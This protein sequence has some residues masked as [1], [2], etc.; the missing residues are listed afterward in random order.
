MSPEL[1]RTIGRYEILKELGRGTMGIVYQARDPQIGR[2]VVVK[3]VQPSGATPREEA[4]ISERFRR[5]AV[6]AGRL[7]HPG[8]VMVHDVGVDAPSGAEY[9]AMEMVAGATLQELAVS[10]APLHVT[11][12]IDDMK[13][14]A[15][16]LD[17]AH[18]Q[19]IVHRDI[20]PSNI[21]VRDDGRLKVADFGVARLA[22]SSLTQAGQVLGSPAY[23]SPEQIAGRRIDGRSDQFS[24]A[25]VV[26]QLLTGRRPFDGDNVSTI[27]HKV[28]SVDP[29]PLHELNKTLPVELSAALL[30]ALAKD[31]AARY[32]SCREMMAALEA[33][34]ARSSTVASP[35]LGPAIAPPAPPPPP[36]PT[37]AP[38][39]SAADIA[40]RVGVPPI[41]RAPVRSSGTPRIALV[42]VLVS[43]AGVLAVVLF[44]RSLPPVEQVRVT[45]PSPAPEQPTAAHPMP[46]PATPSVPQPSASPSI[47]ASSPPAPEPTSTRT[48]PRPATIATAAP[49][50]TPPEEMPS[51]A[52]PEASPSPRTPEATPS[53]A[54]PEP[55]PSPVAT[56]T[57][58]PAAPEIA[59]TT[60]VDTPPPSP[61]D[62]AAGDEAPAEEAAYVFVPKPGEPLPAKLPPTNA[63]LI[64]TVARDVERGRLDV[65]IGGQPVLSQPFNG[66]EQ[67]A[68]KVALPGIPQGAERTSR[69]FPIGISA[70]EHEV[71]VR[72]V[73]SA[74]GQVV[75]AGLVE[76][77]AGQTCILDVG[78]GGGKL[79]MRLRC[80]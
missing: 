25:V 18:A 37:R 17:Y 71:T 41:T 47:T 32:P 14:V 36:P 68:G 78:V 30:R 58:A 23:M 28:V 54:T 72:I 49:K 39:A 57:P 44:L 16:A 76:L 46:A 60:T 42:A 26:Y 48:E 43:L 21:L 75:G 65:A 79:L 22:A 52:A 35:A 56:A 2:I 53:R 11:Q 31:P 1:P 62:P 20:K 33:S 10:A 74:G 66:P 12:V 5:E 15:E 77:Q 19:G 24:L 9:I 4:E 63:A 55:L 45:P 29:A 38:I 13:Q 34:C 3:V 67:D 73:T 70:G 27:F 80:S 59:T 64:V 69:S 6:A 8:I 51:R 61:E 7:S 40:T 50:T